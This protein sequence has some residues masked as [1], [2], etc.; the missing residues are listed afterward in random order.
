MDLVSANTDL[1]V[2]MVWRLII[3]L[4]CV[5]IAGA[6]YFALRFQSNPWILQ[7]FQAFNLVTF[8][9]TILAT[10]FILTKLQNCVSYPCRLYWAIAIYTAI[11]LLLALSTLPVLTIP[12]L[13][14][15]V[16]ILLL[17]FVT[18]IGNGISQN[19]AFAFAAGFDRLEYT[20]GIS[21]GEV[22]AAIMPCVIGIPTF[23]NRSRTNTVRDNLYSKS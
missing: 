12:P 8:S 18:A 14:Y 23:Q 19:A 13:P 9:T 21:M 5:I 4:R 11:P 1:E 17:V 20:P 3:F 6:P 15:F 2:A 16:F 10:D 22:V 7:H